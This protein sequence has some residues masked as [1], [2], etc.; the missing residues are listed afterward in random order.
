VTISKMFAVLSLIGLVLLAPW[1]T[2]AYADRWVTQCVDCPKYFVPMN[3]RGLRLDAGGHPHIAY[4][5]DHLYYAWHDGTNWHYETVDSSSNVGGNGSLALDDS[6]YP[7]I[8]YRYEDG[9]RYA[10][11]DATG[12]HIETVPTNGGDYLSLALDDNGYPHVSHYLGRPDY[13][14]KYTYKDASGWHDEIADDWWVGLHTSLALDGSSRPHISYTSE[15]GGLRYAYKD[16]TGW[17][18]EI[19][20]SDGEVEATS[21]ALDRKGYPHIAYYMSGDEDLRYAY[22]DAIGWHTLTVTSAEYATSSVSLALDSNDYA[23]ISYYDENHPISHLKYA[24][25]NATGWHVEIVE[26]E[27][28]G[29]WMYNSIALDKSGY[30]HFSCLDGANNALV[31][32]RKDGSGWHLQTVDYRG[33]A[34]EYNSLAVDTNGHPHISYHDGFTDG[35]KYAYYDGHAWNFELVDEDDQ[36]GWPQIGDY[37][38]LGLDGDDHPHVS[39]YDGVRQALKYAH[40]DA[41]GWHSEIVDDTGWIGWYTSLALDPD[42]YP[43][44][45]Y[46]AWG[47]KDLRYAYQDT[48][49][50]HIETVDSAGQVGAHTSLTLDGM[51]Y[52]HISYYDA[53]NQALKYAYLDATGWHITTV[54]VG[55]GSYW[56]WQSRTCNGTC[57]SLKLDDVDYPHISYMDTGTGALQYAYL[58]ASGWQTMTVDSE[59]GSYGGGISLAL[60]EDGY[61]HIG[62]YSGDPDFNI[63]YAFQDV[64]GWHTGVVSR[65]YAYSSLALDGDG[66]PH[67]SY[68]DGFDRDLRY[69]YYFVANDAC[70]LP[71]VSKSTP[72]ILDRVGIR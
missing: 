54:A 64:A 61:A 71:I 45:S 10:R 9:L 1:V 3:D 69:A 14:L 15:G 30:P 16:A 24:Y 72:S 28:G 31:Y 4:G 12:W 59:V 35:L 2:P 18:P 22:Q 32:G 26:G 20:D 13:D 56:T 48:G 27:E 38:S 21:L 51:G 40:K 8:I 44:I 19:L 43:H 42:D 41:A 7:H 6:G 11:K 46:Y 25:R 36:V 58:G 23:H 37:T 60:D 52:P 34:G 53:D 62:Y 67:I 65:G 50:W 63:K 68:Y 17:H 66:L 29:W 57:I 39:Y 33:Y 55:I 49:G 47:D 5:G 70:Y